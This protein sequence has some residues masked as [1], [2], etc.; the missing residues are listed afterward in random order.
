MTAHRLDL[1]VGDSHTPGAMGVTGPRWRPA[2]TACGAR[3][4]YF[5]G[6]PRICTVCREE[7]FAN[8][9]APHPASQDPTPMADLTTKQRKRLAASQFALPALRKFPIENAAHVRNAAARIEQEKPRLTPAQYGS[10]KRAIAAA[11]K[12]FGITLAPEKKSGDASPKPGM[13]VVRRRGLHLRFELGPNGA[14]NV[15]VM[16]AGAG[17]GA[18]TMSDAAVFTD[19]PLGIDASAFTD[20]VQKLVDAEAA[21]AA[22][23]ADAADRE[24][25]AAAVTKMRE[26]VA[27][28]RWNQIARVGTFKGHP[29]GPFELT[30]AVFDNIIAN[31]RTVDR[32][33]VCIDFEHAS[34]ADESSGSI[35]QNG[36]PAQ[37]WVLDLQNRGEGGLWG[38]C[39]FLEPALTYVREGKYRFFSPAIRFGAKHPETGAPIGARLTSVGMVNRPFLRGLQPLA[40]SDAA[41]GAHVPMS[42]PQTPHEM[43]KSMKACMGLHPIATGAAM[44][45][46]CADMRD[47]AKPI[48]EKDRTHATGFQA[49]GADLGDFV[50]PLADL[51]GAPAGMSI[52]DILDTVEQM[53][54]DA[55]AAHVEQY[56]SMGDN[57]PAPGAGA[58]DTDVAVKLGQAQEQLRTLTREKGAVV[59]ARDA[60]LGDVSK[61]TLQLSARDA[62]VLEL[63]QTV[64]ARDGELV[65]MRQ[66][67]TSRVEGEQTAIVEEAFATYRESHKLTDAHKTMM[68]ITL[69][70]DPKAF[71][72][73]YPR[74]DPAHRHLPITL[75]ADRLP[76]GGGGG[77]PPPQPPPGGARPQVQPPGQMRMT[78]AA[79]TEL[80][81][82]LMKDKGMGCEDA[83]LLALRVAKGHAANPFVTN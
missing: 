67:E 58:A 62:R 17:A 57:E 51:I 2:C 79:M 49:A 23:P 32:G 59:T 71:F 11:A 81:T 74:V 31:Y 20:A 73:V 3:K 4:G 29:A 83:N 8:P 10:A 25:L 70:Q 42:S 53:I 47:H 21:L 18:V 30:P 68:A 7:F 16:H 36:A 80:A 28:P 44:K 13:Q 54:D 40:A 1:G 38:L 24:V 12:R 65:T 41:P 64:A 63:E 48:L 26:E 35:P 60:A 27:E 77:Q 45:Q 39:R 19:H 76:P 15:D 78:P 55:M 52:G 34:E 33:Q 46:F 14:H 75:A 50:H 5:Q 56:H 66:A 72:G 82:K 43:M 69:R 9:A 22:A 37:G 61:L 6:I